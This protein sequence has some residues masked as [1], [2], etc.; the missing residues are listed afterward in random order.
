MHQLH[1]LRV[2][3]LQPL[4]HVHQGRE[5]GD[6]RRD[7]HLGRVAV[8]QH[9][10]QDRRDRHDR[11]RANG[12][13][14]GVE[15]PLQRLVVD[16]S[17]RGGDRHQIPQREAAEAL[18]DRGNRVVDEPGALLHQR[19]PDGRR[20]GD[21]VGGDIEDADQRVPHD[22]ED[23]NHRQREQETAEQ[24]GAGGGVG[25]HGRR[26]A[27]GRHRFGG[28]GGLHGHPPWAS[29]RRSAAVCRTN[30]GASLTD[31]CRGDGRSILTSSMTRPGRGVKTKIRL[32][33]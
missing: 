7:R 20:G 32:A 15:R 30:S 22:D 26:R 12:H 14:H 23:G 25:R 27:V 4:D 16:E 8:A 24:D 5:E 3:R 31:G 13:R 28:R 21:H 19:L 29:A 6:Q 2:G 9:Q 17:D 1:R 11:E 10:H 18:H 33:R